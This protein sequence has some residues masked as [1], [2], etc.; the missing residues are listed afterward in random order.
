M[1]LTLD[2]KAD[3]RVQ[4]MIALLGVITSEI[5]AIRVRVDASERLTL[6]AY[7]ERV[8]LRFEREL[9]QGAAAE[10]AGTLYDAVLTSRCVCIVAP[11]P[12]MG[13][14]EL[15]DFEERNFGPALFDYWH[16]VRFGEVPG[17]EED[18][19]DNGAVS[20]D[21]YIRFG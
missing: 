12:I 19:E 2:Q 14:K 5:R 20:P 11:G 17:D 21:E 7:F 6:L 18:R 13:V 3:L 8:P 10:A 1:N 15:V 16:Y 4:M 9:L